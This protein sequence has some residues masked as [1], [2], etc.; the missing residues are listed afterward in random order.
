[1]DH[2]PRY[3]F[4][5]TGDAGNDLLERGLCP[6]AETLFSKCPL[7]GRLS[8]DIS[9]SGGTI[10]LSNLRDRV[11][12]RIETINASNKIR[13]SFMVLLTVTEST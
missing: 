11:E 4:E 10:V 5:I 6:S 2:L 7:L 12:N 9:V 13:T 3:N 8:S 1:M